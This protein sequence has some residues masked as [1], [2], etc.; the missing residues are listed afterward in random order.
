MNRAEALPQHIIAA[1]KTEALERAVLFSADE[2]RAFAMLV[3]RANLDDTTT[4]LGAKRGQ[5]TE[6]GLVA[7]E[8]Q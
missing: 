6:P 4:R 7:A 8:L 5:D 3:Q 2:A 1:L